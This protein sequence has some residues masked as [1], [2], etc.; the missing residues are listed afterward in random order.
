MK[1]G[2]TYILSN[3]KRT[4]LYVGMTNDIEVRVLQHKA[5][6]GSKYTAKYHLKY[7]MHFEAFSSIEQA[8]EREKQLKNWHKEWKW[9][10]IKESNPELND[11]AEDWFDEDD[12][13][14]VKTGN[15]K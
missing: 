3:A 8:I 5:G 2:Y 14:S 7:L 10:L 11:L 4:L 13:E 6:T 9:N 1:K 15:L 12:I